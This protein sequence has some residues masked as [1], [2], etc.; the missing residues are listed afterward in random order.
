MF[1]IFY[2]LHSEKRSYFGN[3]RTA[4]SFSL[5]QILCGMKPRDQQSCRDKSIELILLYIIMKDI[6]GFA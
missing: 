2:K 5:G 3:G 4:R 6:F 1:A